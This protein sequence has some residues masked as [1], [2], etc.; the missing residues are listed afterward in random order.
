[1]GKRKLIKFEEMKTFPNVFQPPVNDILNHDHALKGRWAA[2]VF[3]NSRPIV[4]ELGCGKGEYTVGLAKK[5]PEKNFIGIDIKGARIWTGASEALREGLNN[6]V[7]LRTRI[8]LMEAFFSAGE[9]SEIWLTFPD[10]QLKR[11]RW[12]KRLIAPSFLN[13]YNRFLSR[14]GIIHLKTDCRQ[15]YEY[16][17]NLLKSNGIQPVLATENLYASGIQDDVAAIQTFYEQQYLAAGLNI[18]YL[19]FI[20]GIV[21][22]FIDLTDEEH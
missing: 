15:L 12:K 2:E 5:Y 4:L 9:I 11:R 16:T 8:E 20:P 10:P 22:H 6:V 17:L 18:H 1:M 19:R 3:H 7:F 21:E 14:G 13:I